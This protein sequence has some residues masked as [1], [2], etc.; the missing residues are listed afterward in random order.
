MNTDKATLL[1]LAKLL[2]AM[3]ADELERF[4]EGT[5]NAVVLAQQ[6]FRDR[7]PNRWQAFNDK[8]DRGESGFA[9]AELAREES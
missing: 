4:C 9:V 5:M 2:K 7:F 1:E 6:V 8:I 3:N